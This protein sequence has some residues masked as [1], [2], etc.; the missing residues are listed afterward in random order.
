MD[1]DKITAWRDVMFHDTVCLANGVN[2][3]TAPSA[4]R[5]S[6]PYPSLPAYRRLTLNDLMT[7]FIKVPNTTW[8]ILGAF[9]CGVAFS[10]NVLNNNNNNGNATRSAAWKV[11]MTAGYTAA[12]FA[13][14]RL[15]RV[16]TV[17]FSVESDVSSH[18][19]GPCR[20]TERVLSLTNSHAGTHADT[21]AHFC[22]DGHAADYPDE[23]YTG[24]AVVLDLSIQL[25][26]VRHGNPRVIT[27]AMVESVAAES[28][29]D[30]RQVYRLL[31]CSR[32]HDGHLT[33]ESP[34]DVWDPESAYLDPECAKYLAGLPNLLLLGIDTPSIDA[35]TAA[36]LCDNSHGA[37]YAGRVAILENLDFTSL[38]D[39]FHY[40]GSLYGCVVTTFMP[41]ETY[42]DA[43]GAVA[44]FYPNY[45]DDNVGM[46]E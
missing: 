33:T 9:T 38:S 25:Q 45:A 46:E 16:V 35:P 32:R 11:A 14:C 29:V 10:S 42:S 30:L 24:S 43:R 27:C 4:V 20:V 39:H 28:G 44:H 37:L 40:Y 22:R 17:P 34:A 1:D 12:L 13:W 36:P 3:S 7:E 41:N 23:H 19:G 2:I 8:S 5:A 26:V 18:P 6:F 31:L 21:A 15:R